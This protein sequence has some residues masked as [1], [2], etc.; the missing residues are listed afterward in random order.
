MSQA[1][2]RS[3]RP[4]TGA[5]EGFQSASSS[6]GATATRRR[7]RAY[8]GRSALPGDRFQPQL[9]TSGPGR[10]DLIVKQEALNALSLAPEPADLDVLLEHVSPS[11]PE[12]YGQSRPLTAVAQIAKLVGVSK[13]RGALYTARDEAE[14][15]EVK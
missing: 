1:L 14:S 7:C 9:S 8:R 2:R 4:S 6:L 5:M 11:P 12:I 15:P 13:V 3:R 10:K